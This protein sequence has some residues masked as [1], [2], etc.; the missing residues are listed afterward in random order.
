MKR[1]KQWMGI[2]LTIMLMVGS[3][4]MPV[5]A[6]DMKRAAFEA[7]DLDNTDIFP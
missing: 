1:M 7:V 2:I 5:Y 6:E 3:M 4:Q